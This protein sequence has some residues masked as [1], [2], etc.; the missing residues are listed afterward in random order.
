MAN[1]IERFLAAIAVHKS[2]ASAHHAKYTDAEAQAIADARIALH[3]A[4]AAAHHAVHLKTLADHVLGTVVPHDALASLTERAHSSLT[5]IGP[6]DHHAKYTDAEAQAIA[7]AQIAIHAALAAAH[8]AKFTTTEHDVVARHPLSVL[9]PSV[10]SETEADGKITTHKGDASAHHTKT[11]K[12]SEIT[13]EQFP[14]DR[15]P[16]AASGFLEGKGVGSNPAYSALIEADIPAHMAKSKLA[17]TANK[18]LKGA[19]AGADPTEIDVP[20]VTASLEGESSGLREEHHITAALVVGADSYTDETFSFATAFSAAPIVITSS[21]QES[22]V[23]TN[24]GVAYK[25]KT[26]GL[27]PSTSSVVLRALNGW[28]GEVT[29]KIGCI[30]IGS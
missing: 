30:A 19:G 28:T 29:F 17:F 5:G 6:S 3:A 7:D 12:A 20:D 22:S 11:S 15:M 13:S 8:H 27:A 2:N 4:I 1:W 14:L 9:D 24:A 25:L 23:D 16:R 21:T 26:L 10:C 18:L